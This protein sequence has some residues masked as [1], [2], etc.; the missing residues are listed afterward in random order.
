MSLPAGFGPP[1]DKH[2]EAQA[3]KR[4]LSVVWVF[5]SMLGLFPLLAVNDWIDE[6]T[7]LGLRLLILVLAFGIFSSLIG[8]YLSYVATIIRFFA[9]ALPAAGGGGYGY[10]AAFGVSNAA[11][12]LGCVWLNRVPDV[13]P[14]LFVGVALAAPWPALWLWYRIRDRFHDSQRMLQP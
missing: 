8:G 2:A 7:S 5:A 1:R 4:A 3:Y 14:L 6:G 11:V 10:R 9:R 13:W 12:F